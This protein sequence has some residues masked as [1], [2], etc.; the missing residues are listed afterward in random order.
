MFPSLTE[1]EW[2]W[3]REKESFPKN[4]RLDPEPMEGFDEEPVFETEGVPDPRNDAIF[5]EEEIG[6]LGFY[7]Y[8][9]FVRRKFE[10]C[11]KRWVFVFSKRIHFLQMF[12]GVPNV[13]IIQNR[14]NGTIV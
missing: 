5:F 10:H 13:C 9:T 3:V 2:T 11:F 14:I 7:S 1:E 8:L 6:F 12:F 4:P